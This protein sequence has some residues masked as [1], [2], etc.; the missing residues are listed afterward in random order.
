ML[1]KMMSKE[2][3]KQIAAGEIV[4]RPASVVKELIENSLDAE[5]KNI[6][7]NVEK[8]GKKLIQIYDDGHGIKKEEL[9]LALA[10]YSTS[11][12]YKI[13]DLDAIKS[14]GFR[15]EALY[16]ISSVS[17]CSLISRTQQQ[18]EG[19]KIYSEGEQKNIEI[20]PI[21]HPYGTTIEILDLFY[22]V[23][24]RRK[25]LRTEATEFLHLDEIIKILAL[26][27]FYVS[28]SVNHNNK[29]VRRYRSVNK[30][31]NNEKRIEDVIGSNFIINAEKV[32]YFNNN[33]SLKGWIIN[34]LKNIKGKNIQYFYINKR[35]VRNN[36]LFQCIRKATKNYFYK[37]INFCYVLYFTIEP[38]KIDV[39][40]H[41]K[42][43]EVRFYE[44]KLV[45]NFIYEAISKILINKKNFLT[46]NLFIEKKNNFYNKKKIIKNHIL[47]KNDE[48][49]EKKHETNTTQ[50]INKLEI[51]NHDISKKFVNFKKVITI[52][53]K[54]VALI[55][56]NTGLIFLDL[57]LGLIFLKKVQLI[58]YSSSLYKKKHLLLFPIK[59]HI[60]DNEKK[61]LLIYH[62]QLQ[63][64][65]INFKQDLNYI[66]LYQIPKCLRIK[67]LENLILNLLKYLAQ[68][69][70]LS[71]NDLLDWLANA[72]TEKNFY[73]NTFQVT[74]FI[75]NIQL[76]CKN[77]F[78]T[79]FPNFLHEINIEKL[80]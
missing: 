38:Q 2:L 33:Y 80:F 41:P 54:K 56:N 37:D 77:D 76:I 34:P 32:N 22:N 43:S 50:A 4:E 52:F 14:F 47:L 44:P 71:L 73:S 31:N 65:G 59:I 74:A 6:N 36:I 53:K 26:S 62:K 68:N 39:N 42:K 5:A 72:S 15:G 1:I 24:V 67:H 21:A 11:K 45:Y 13:E 58:Q 18:K 69:S 28:I 25:F 57:Q 79:L 7:I 27:N 3:I 46:N 51:S 61:S 30:F 35:I 49:K 40:I 9:S 16:S 75:K 29:N 20:Q 63:N 19:W 78:K 23:P 48:C 17:R 64:I 66:T 55:E 10:R 70:Y 8:G 12:I 60:N